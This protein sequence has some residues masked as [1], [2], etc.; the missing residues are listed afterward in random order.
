M[1]KATPIDWAAFA[2]QIRMAAELTADA[3][4]PDDDWGYLATGEQIR[5]TAVST[6]TRRR[7]AESRSGV[8]TRSR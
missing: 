5:S 1:R 8:R 2:S 4:Y 6:S 3:S 7:T